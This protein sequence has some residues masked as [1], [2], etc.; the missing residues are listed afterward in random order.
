MSIESMAVGGVQEQTSSGGIADFS[1]SEG[2][3]DGQMG[4][5]EFLE[6]LTAQLQTRYLLEHARGFALLTPLLDWRATLLPE[7]ALCGGKSEAVG[8]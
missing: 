6:L 7:A 8:R 4:K 3:G 2:T 5:L 1:F